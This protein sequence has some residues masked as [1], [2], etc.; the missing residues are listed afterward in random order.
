MKATVLVKPNQ[1][2]INVLKNEKGELIIS[3]NATPIDGKAN[4]ALIEI[5]ADYFKVR[6]SSITILHGAKG[7][8]KIIEIL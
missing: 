7:K 2:K 8:R 4:A 5:L 3:V 1:K 6:K